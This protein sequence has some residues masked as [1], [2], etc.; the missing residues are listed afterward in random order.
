M[1]VRPGVADVHSITIAGFRCRA[2]TRVRS[3]CCASARGATADQ[4]SWDVPL[5]ACSAYRGRT[6]AKT[7]PARGSSPLHDDR[8][9]VFRDEVEVALQA[10]GGSSPDAAK[11]AVAL[12]RMGLGRLDRWPVGEEFERCRVA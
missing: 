7:A 8:R 11:E 2:E 9:V 1:A 3:G 10:G 6:F 5:P 4:G 12:F